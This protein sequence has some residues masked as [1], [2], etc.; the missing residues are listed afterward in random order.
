MWPILVGL[1]VA[2]SVL[3]YLN[4]K[5]ETT[6]YSDNPLD[7][8]LAPHPSLPDLPKP[9]VPGGLLNDLA[10]LPPV[11]VSIPTVSAMDTM[12]GAAAGAL[13]TVVTQTDPLMLRAAPSRNAPILASMPP[14]SQVAILDV[15][16]GWYKVIYKKQVG[17]ASADYVR[18]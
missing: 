10:A 2:G 6:D 16:N 13:G 12:T 3:Y 9:P 1:G 8:T 17:Y 5:S 4:R 15:T 11:N 7:K 14:G 18:T